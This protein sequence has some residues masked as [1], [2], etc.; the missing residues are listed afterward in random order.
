MTR[1]STARHSARRGSPP[2]SA[3]STHRA[4]SRSRIAAA[5]ACSQ[6]LHRPSRI[7]SSCAADRFTAWPSNPGKAFSSICS[8]MSSAYREGSPPQRVSGT[9]P[10]VAQAR[11]RAPRRRHLHRADPAGNSSRPE[12]STS[13][14]RDA[15]P[16]CFLFR[17]A[18]GRMFKACL[19]H[20]AAVAASIRGSTSSRLAARRSVAVSGGH[21]S[22]RH[23]TNA[24]GGNVVWLR[25]SGRAGDRLY[26]AHLDRHGRSTAPGSGSVRRRSASGYVGN[27]GNA[28]TTAPHLHFGI[29]RRGQGAIDP[30][31][32]V[33]DPP[34]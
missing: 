19:A 14:T 13:R 22:A 27:T 20:P 34:P 17:A 23:R 26:Y 33:V 31:Y 29:Y 5:S 7:V 8:S 4:Q 28:R 32:Y 18:G 3:R 10:P 2:A 24:L 6:T 15:P 12:R 1:A 25:R 21:G 16:C 9:G 30:L 11:V